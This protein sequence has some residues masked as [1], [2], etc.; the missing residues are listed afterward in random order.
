MA[1]P[2]GTLWPP[3]TL[4][5]ARCDRQTSPKETLVK[6]LLDY[7]RS[8]LIRALEKTRVAPPERPRGNDDPVSRGIED[9]DGM[10]FQT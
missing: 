2:L 1:F 3:V 8:A 9:H 10:A 5:A 7:G 6:R 4:I